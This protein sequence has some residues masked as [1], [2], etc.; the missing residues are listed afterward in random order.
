MSLSCPCC[1]RCSQKWPELPPF[2]DSCPT[3]AGLPKAGAMAGRQGERTILS[4]G[5]GLP[6]VWKPWAGAWPSS[7]S[8]NSSPEKLGS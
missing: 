4:V 5:R 8:E 1:S 6:P 2:P 7:S 3:Q